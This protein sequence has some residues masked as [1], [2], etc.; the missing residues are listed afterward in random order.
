MQRVDRREVVTQA[1][2]EAEEHEAETRKILHP[3]KKGTHCE[4]GPW[5]KQLSLHVVTVQGEMHTRKRKKKNEPEEKGGGVFP[6]MKP[7]RS[8]GSEKGPDLISKVR[9]V[10]R[11]QF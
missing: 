3:K 11:G 1:F 8:R 6:T 9:E 5:K 10:T 4:K 7:L 2:K